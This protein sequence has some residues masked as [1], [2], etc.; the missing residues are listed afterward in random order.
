MSVFG[1]RCCGWAVE[2]G[3]GPGSGR[4]GSCY[5]CV[6]CESGFFV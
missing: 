1:L 3:L 2:G 4:V 6:S 5:I